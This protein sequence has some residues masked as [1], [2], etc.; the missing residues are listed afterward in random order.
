[1]D[2]NFQASKIAGSGAD[3]LT[4][5]ISDVGFV[6]SPLT[7]GTQIG[8]TFSGSITQVTD[9]AFFDNTNVNFGTAGG[10]SAL[11]TF[12]TTPFSGTGSLAVS[13]ATPYS[14]TEQIVIT[15]GAG[16]GNTS[17]DYELSVPAPAGLI[18]ALS[19]TPVL[20]F[21]AWLRRRRSSAVA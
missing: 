3:T 7:L 4:I 20:G 16:A 21:G 5:A 9:Q 11:Q 8:G 15:A 13:G 6:T 18:L 19:G 14:L 12:T 10:S 17:G 2:L 1:M